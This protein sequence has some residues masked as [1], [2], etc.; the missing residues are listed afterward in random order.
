M[1]GAILGDIRSFY[2]KLND[3]G[4][5]YLVDKQYK[6]TDRTVAMIA[7]ADALTSVN[8][9]DEENLEEKI[10]ESLVR[11]GKEYYNANYSSHFKKWLAQKEHSPIHEQDGGAAARAT[12]IPYLYHDCDR[13]FEIAKL[14]MRITHGDFDE[15]KGNFLQ[16][17]FDSVL[18]P[19]A[20]HY[21]MRSSGKNG[22]KFNFEI[23]AH[24][25]LSELISHRVFVGEAMED[26][27]NSTDVSSAIENAIARGGDI[28]TRA[29]IAGSIA[30]GFYGISNSEKEYCNRLLPE[31]MLEVLD[32]F[33]NAARRNFIKVSETEED[34]TDEIIEDAIRRYNKH[35]S[36][37]NHS[38]VMNQLY[39]GMCS[40]GNLRIPIV[41]SKDND[42]LTHQTEDGKIYVVAFTNDSPEMCETYPDIYL[43]TIE[44]VFTEL[45]D[46]EETSGIIL[47]PDDDN[48]RFILDKEDFEEILN[49]TPPENKM[50]FIDGSIEELNTD[51]IVSSDFE[52]FKDIS[53][54]NPNEI[55]EAHFMKKSSNRDEMRII[56]TPLIFYSGT[57]EEIIA[58][59]YFSCL[60]LAKK[61]HLSSVAF[62]KQFDSPF[63]NDV[64]RSWLDMNEGC[65][66][67][68]FV[69][70]GNNEDI[71]DDNDQERSPVDYRNEPITETNS[72]D[73][74]KAEAYRN[75]VEQAKNQYPEYRSDIKPTDADKQRTR[76]F[77]ATFNSKQAFWDA[78]QY[79]CAKWEKSDDTDLN[80]E[81]ARESLT[82]AIANGFDPKAPVALFAPVVNGVNIC[83]E[84]NLYTY[85]QGFGY[86]KRT[87]KIKY[88]LVAQDWGNLFRRDEKDNEGFLK[89]NETGEWIPAYEEVPK[90]KGTDANLFQL[91][92]VLDRDLLKL[93]DDVFFTNF[94]LGYRLGNESGGMTKDLMM[95]DA[96]LFLELCNILEPENILCLGKITSECVYEALL[97]GNSFGE[98]YSGYKNYNDFLDNHP[99]IVIP[100]GDKNV[101]NFYPLA[102]C[103]YMGTMGRN[104]GYDLPEIKADILFKQRQDWQKIVDEKKIDMAIECFY[105]TN[106]PEDKKRVLNEISSWAQKD[107]NFIIALNEEPMQFDTFIPIFQNMKSVFLRNKH[108]GKYC[109]PAFTNLFE[110]AKFNEETGR[111]SCFMFVPVQKLLIDCMKGGGMGDE[112]IL[113]PAGNQFRLTRDIIKDLLV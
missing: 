59:C 39:Y 66:M 23:N 41:G 74:A 31:S 4:I 81:R 109:L 95:R 18:T 67:T 90:G 79:R 71:D 89:M 65:G 99:Q 57:D 87:P 24:L 7:L 84:I 76:D 29:I 27:F 13:I 34:L 92:K 106:S 70:R 110:F 45:A 6:F 12:V 47:N 33:D 26:F 28:S 63:M 16:S 14:S 108:D 86:A 19:I 96:K 50:L 11:W 55:L 73:S 69:E 64:V 30:E 54:E 17:D 15:L 97:I 42:Y 83:N 22:V 101:S 25:K 88:L 78:L 32:R 53:F 107:E 72:A 51:A 111:K 3:G 46:D 91:F 103:G 94:C 58:N 49:R 113:N 60:E 56:Y 93:N 68:V 2:H 112:I 1:Y 5:C 48:L 21:G 43:G 35:D 20:V 61:Y 104:K 10:K 77:A 36:I 40:G 38:N 80:D 52:D 102:H 9:N 85:W 98:I 62:P 44:N 100:Y 37:K 82:I 8:D 105:R 75:L